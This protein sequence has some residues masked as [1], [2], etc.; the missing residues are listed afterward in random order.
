MNTKRSS[1]PTWIFHRWLVPLIVVLVGLSACSTTPPDGI[2]A[3]TPFDISRYMGKWYEVAR[4]DHS[5]ERGLSDVSA[6]YQAQAD[7][8]VT[9]INR[10]F[11]TKKSEWKE[12]VGK[13]KFIGD[14]QRASLKVSFFG[15][16]YGGYHV[17][18]LDQKDYRWAM[19]VG[20]NRDYLWIL[21]RD[22]HLPSGVREQLLAQAQQ[23]GIDVSKLIWVE[24][25][26][27]DS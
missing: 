4:L 17:M 20:P 9:V 2:T 23:N 25:T 24:Q 18:A 10:G 13:A 6:Q 7:G 11:N 12:A 15:P 26:R 5:F 8:S 27:N 22:K 3:V 19:V 1:T 21:C 16:F 14:N